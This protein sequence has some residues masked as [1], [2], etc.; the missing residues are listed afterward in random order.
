MGLMVGITL[1]AVAP[2]IEI[3]PDSTP[4]LDPSL[5][6]DYRLG[7]SAPVD[8]LPNPLPYAQQTVPGTLSRVVQDLT[9]RDVPSIH[10]PKPGS[11][12]FSTTAPIPTP[13]ALPLSFD[14]ITVN[15]PNG[16]AG[17]TLDIALAAL[18]SRADNNSQGSVNLAPTRVWS[19]GVIYPYA[20]TG[21]KCQGSSI[22]TSSGRTPYCL[23]LI[24]F[25][26]KDGDP[27]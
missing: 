19:R 8:G 18:Y 26:T 15:P 10:H 27:V 16:S 24:G 9:L 13:E 11:A 6:A 23:D 5:P 21:I 17:S 20:S 12:T 14:P 3:V 4:A 7:S 22:V 2:S 1:A 25:S